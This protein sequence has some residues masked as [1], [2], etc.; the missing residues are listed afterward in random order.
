MRR[1]EA[2]NPL[3][4]PLMWAETANVKNRLQDPPRNDLF[5]MDDGFRSSGGLDG[6]DRRDRTAN[7]PASRRTGL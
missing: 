2:K 5:S 4:R 1:L 7:S 6:G 3:E